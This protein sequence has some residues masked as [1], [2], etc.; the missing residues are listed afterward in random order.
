MKLFT[1]NTAYQHQIF[2]KKENP[3]AYRELKSKIF[4]Y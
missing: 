1:N 3:L 4:A 2:F